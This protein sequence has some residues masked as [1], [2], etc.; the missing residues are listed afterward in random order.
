[1]PLHTV[2]LRARVCASDSYDIG[3]VSEV[4]QRYFIVV[5]ASSKSVYHIP[6]GSIREVRPSGNV[7]LS[8]KL[9]KT[10][11]FRQKGAAA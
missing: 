5:N 3:S 11:Q 9:E 7:V 2:S 8:C 10:D 1:M 4:K 6:F